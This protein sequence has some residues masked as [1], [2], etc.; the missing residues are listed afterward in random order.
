MSIGNFTNQLVNTGKS[1]G[2]GLGKAVDKA[3]DGVTKELKEAEDAFN[4]GTLVEGATELLDATSTGTAVTSALSAIGLVP[5]NGPGKEIVSALVN[6]ATPVPTAPLAGMK[7]LADALAGMPSGRLAPAPAHTP[8]APKQQ[9]NEIHCGR[10]HRPHGWIHVGGGFGFGHNHGLRP[11]CGMNIYLKFGPGCPIMMSPGRM[12]MDAMERLI[13]ALLKGLRPLPDV[14]LKPLPHPHPGVEKPNP[15]PKPIEDLKDPNDAS[16]QD[17]LNDPKL[18]FEDKLF[19]FMCKFIQDQE[20]E[21]KKQMAYMDTQKK[22]SQ[23]ASSPDGSKQPSD[24]AGGAS[25]N[26]QAVSGLDALFGAIK[27]KGLGGVMG[28][29]NGGKGAGSFK[30]PL[31]EIGGLIQ[32]ASVLAPVIAPMLSSACAGIPYVGPFL[33]A[34]MP[35]LLPVAMNLVG[36]ALQGADPLV[37]NALAQMMKPADDK[38]SPRERRFYAGGSGDFDE[39]ARRT[40][41][42]KRNETVGAK[43][44][45]DPEYS[46][47]MEMEKLKKMTQD[48]QKMQN[49]LSNVLNN[50]HNSAMNAIRNI[51]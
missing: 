4:K 38:S 42:A 34:A 33:A 43:S 20:E 40:G 2:N 15:N 5:E 51:K 46:E 6:F 36:G 28:C 39:T 11:G 9:Y 50:M 30:L 31:K 23:N 25:N 19:L 3:F 16:Y 37:N 21:I 45:K 49:A 13:K 44:A 1:I 7:D 26:P 29:L 18:T 41:P 8:P 47:A 35:V 10:V 48:L 17:I 32:G 27:D 24:N 22:Q 14:N 12:I